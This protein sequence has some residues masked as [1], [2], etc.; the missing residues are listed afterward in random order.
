MAWEFQKVRGL[1]FL[2]IFM[3]LAGGRPTLA[4]IRST[5]VS[6]FTYSKYDCLQLVREA[7]ALSA[8]AAA[9]GGLQPS[10]RK[11]DA[12]DTKSAVIRWPGV[13]ALLGDRSVADDL[14]LMRGQMFAIE[15]AS[16]RSQ[17]SIQFER[18]LT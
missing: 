16:V 9:M 6:P 15:E 3:L 4:E 12:N 11:G 5:Y 10:P 1:V 7:R 13:F 2:A 8:R 17:C 18:P 14:A